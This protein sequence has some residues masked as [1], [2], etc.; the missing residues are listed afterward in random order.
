MIIFQI[1]NIKYILTVIDE[2]PRQGYNGSSTTCSRKR[3]RSFSRSCSRER[4]DDYKP[5]SLQHL[6]SPN[7]SNRDDCYKEGQYSSSRQD[8]RSRSNYRDRKSSRY[9]KVRKR[10]H[11]SSSSQKHRGNRDEPSPS[12]CLKVS[13]LNSYTSEKHLKNLF[14]R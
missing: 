1:S 14:S 11:S 2:S 8:S 3:G 6:D 10:S 4:H 7:Y 13:G 9:S 12:K 5:I